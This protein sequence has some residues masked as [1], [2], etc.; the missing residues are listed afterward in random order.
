M[1]LKR[2]EEGRCLV[3]C[4]TP[5]SRCELLDYAYVYTCFLYVP[6]RVC[7]LVFLFHQMAEHFEG[8]AALTDFL[9]DQRSQLGFKLIIIMRLHPSKWALADSNGR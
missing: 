3:L 8:V 1:I 4:R 5:R 9:K 6:N 7:S 2:R